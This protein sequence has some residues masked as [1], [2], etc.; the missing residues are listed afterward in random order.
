V[1]AQQTVRVLQ[2]TWTF[3]KAQQEVDIHTWVRE[4]LRNV[5][6]T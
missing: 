4:A 5:L 2:D 1:P 3:F 6:E